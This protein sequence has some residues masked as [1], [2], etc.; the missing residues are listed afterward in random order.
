[1][2][3]ILE[4]KEVDSKTFSEMSKDVERLEKITERFSKIGSP[5][6]LQEENVVKVIYESINYLKSRTSKR[7]CYSINVPENHNIIIP[8]NAHLFGW[9]IENLCKNAVDAMDG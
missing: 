2:V 7:V 9:V 5:P 3:E 1:W 4:S 6:K 8:L